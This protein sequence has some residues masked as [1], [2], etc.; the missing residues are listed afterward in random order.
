MYII[1]EIDYR[2]VT[3]DGWPSW[4]SANISFQ[5]V[6]ELDLTFKLWSWL[7]RLGVRQPEDIALFDLHTPDGFQIDMIPV[8]YDFTNQCATWGDTVL[9]GKRGK[10]NENV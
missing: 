5:A 9:F 2:H 4:Q 1:A 3:P 7:N 10:T 8:K 6:D